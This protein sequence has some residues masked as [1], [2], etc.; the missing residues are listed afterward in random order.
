MEMIL[1]GSLGEW[2][3][4][5]G[6]ILDMIGIYFLTLTGIFVKKPFRTWIYLWRHVERGNPEQTE[7]DPPIEQISPPGGGLASDVPPRKTTTYDRQYK[8][9][10]RLCV[11]TILLLSGLGLQLVGTLL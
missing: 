4:S 6:I 9:V 7:K 2:I 10:G 1:S 3:I 5:A 11:G 8:L